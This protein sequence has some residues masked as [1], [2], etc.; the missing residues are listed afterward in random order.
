MVLKIPY[1]WLWSYVIRLN[2]S[3]HRS[4]SCIN[5]ISNGHHFRFSWMVLRWLQSS[6]YFWIRFKHATHRCHEVAVTWISL[7]GN[8]VRFRLDLRG[9]IGQYIATPLRSSWAWSFSAWKVLV[10]GPL[11]KKSTMF[12][13]GQKR[14]PVNGVD[15]LVVIYVCHCGSSGTSLNLKI[16]FVLK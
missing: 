7:I 15:N 16:W 11:C 4:T 1:R 13:H 9:R 14:S 8:T 12:P 10:A 6:L 3:V 5:E 2:Y